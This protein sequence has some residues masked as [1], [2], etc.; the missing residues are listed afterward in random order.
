MIQ[1]H[2]GLVCSPEEAEQEEGKDLIRYPQ[3][4]AN[5]KEFCEKCHE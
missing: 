1:K 3:T 4:T 2:V 5:R